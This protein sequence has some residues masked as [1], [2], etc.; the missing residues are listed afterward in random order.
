VQ[1]NSSALTTTQ[2]ENL[3][4]AARL[5]AGAPEER[6]SGRRG[7]QQN[8]AGDNRNRGGNNQHR[9]TR[10]KKSTILTK[11]DKISQRQPTKV[12]AR[13]RCVVF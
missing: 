8:R 12:M 1:K 9:N 2:I 13:I 6:D 5:A 3:G 11:I 10:P 4:C 7:N